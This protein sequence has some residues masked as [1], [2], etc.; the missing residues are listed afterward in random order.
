MKS[1]LFVGAFAAVAV[2]CLCGCGASL[3]P[4][5]DGQ[6]AGVI[7][8]SSLEAPLNAVGSAYGAPAA[9]TAFVRADGALVQRR[10]PSVK[11][12][13]T[14]S[15]STQFLDSAGSDVK[16][17]FDGN[18]SP[19][20]DMVET[21]VYGPR[22]TRLSLGPVSAPPIVV[23]QDMIQKALQLYNEAAKASASGVPVALPPVLGAPVQQLPDDVPAGFEAIREQ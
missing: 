20:L 16:P 12:Y 8:V 23:D 1:T 11:P 10:N 21:P 6:I 18:G 15:V 5:L 2:S 14:V 4:D 7:P 19:Y 13:P 22:T 9:G 3:R 17:F